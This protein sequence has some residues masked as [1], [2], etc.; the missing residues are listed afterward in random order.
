MRAVSEERLVELSWLIDSV[1]VLISR[2]QYGGRRLRFSEEELL[3]MLALRPQS[4]M[5]VEASFDADSKRILSKL[6]AQGRVRTVS[7]AGVR[8]YGA[9]LGL[10]F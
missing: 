4:E 10:N 6:L 9:Y 7:L 8:F 1:P 2:R 5:D 3:K